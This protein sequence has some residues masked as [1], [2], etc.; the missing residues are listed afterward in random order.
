MQTHAVVRIKA[1]LNATQNRNRFVFARLVH[2]HRLES[3]FQSRILF[4]VLAV[5]LSR[6]CTN[7]MEFAT[8]KFRLKHIAQVHRAFSLTSPHNVVE[9]IDEHKRVAIFFN[10]VNH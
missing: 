10:S 2:L 1:I 8:S 5:F 9:F 7:A 6:R 4:N 3:T